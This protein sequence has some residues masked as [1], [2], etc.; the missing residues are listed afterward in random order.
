M[1]DPASDDKT[2]SQTIH[3]WAIA[4]HIVGVVYTKEICRYKRGSN[5]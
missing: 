2:N 5:L 3:C 4:G 1:E